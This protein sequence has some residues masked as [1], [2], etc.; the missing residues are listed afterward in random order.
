MKNETDYISSICPVFQTLKGVPHSAFVHIELYG[1]GIILHLKK[2]KLTEY[3][4]DLTS[5][6][7]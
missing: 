2:C 3:T 4:S 1:T 5:N 7:G 6:R